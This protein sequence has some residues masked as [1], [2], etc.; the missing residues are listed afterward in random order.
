MFLM[1]SECIS[2][3]DVY[4]ISVVSLLVVSGISQ[5][6]FNLTLFHFL[7]LLLPYFVTHTK[8]ED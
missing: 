6:L 7:L 5:K 2:L 4:L 1:Y 3:L 8:N